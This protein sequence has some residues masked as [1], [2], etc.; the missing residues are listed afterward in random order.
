[1]KRL[2]ILLCLLLALPLT[3]AAQDERPQTAQEWYDYGYESYWM[4]ELEMA[5]D[6]FERAVTL[7]STFA[8]AYAYRGNAA[9]ALGDVDSAS[10]DVERALELEPDLSIAY[11]VRARINIDLG[12][13]EEALSNLEIAIDLD[14]DLWEAYY[15]RA[16]INLATDPFQAWLDASQ[17]IERGGDFADVYSVRG[18]ALSEMGDLY[19]AIEDLTIA[20]EMLDTVASYYNNRGRNYYQ[21]GEYALAIDDL[22]VAI[23]LAPGQYMSYAVRGLAWRA[24]D[25][26]ENA[27]ADYTQEIA[28]SPDFADVYLN[29]GV[30]YDELGQPALALDDYRVALALTDDPLI[31]AYAFNNS[32]MIYLLSYYEP[33]RALATV[34]RAIEINPNIPRFVY[35]RGRILL[36]LEY[37]EAAIDAFTRAIA[38]IPDWSTAYYRRAEAYMMLGEFD[39]ALVDIE[40]ALALEPNNQCFD[41][42]FLMLSDPDFVATIDPEWVRETMYEV[43]ARCLE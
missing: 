22:T 11:V 23:D 27:I 12:E 29:R 42:W 33:E 13:T 32:G 36:A 4:H 24:L 10:D 43:G 8:A 15:Y 21:I 18:L 1:M 38:F 6:A 31:R 30:C 41:A 39:L 40:A 3:V 16:T 5:L 2:I 35:N 26:C 17:A 37:Y 9:R 14:P 19:G 28:Y 20:I 34:D 7:D 25:E